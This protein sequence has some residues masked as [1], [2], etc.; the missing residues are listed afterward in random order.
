MEEIKE[1]NVENKEPF[2]AKAK[3]WF[4]KKIVALKRKPQLIYFVFSV[5]VTFLYLCWLFT[6]SRTIY[7]NQAVSWAGLMVFI[8]T[9]VSILLLAL[10]FNAFPKRSK[11]KIVFIVLM[12]VF[13]A[14]IVACDL[15][16][17]IEMN[18]Y[19]VNRSGLTDADFADKPYMKQS[20]TLA[21]T[22]VVLVGIEAI[23][24]ATLPLYKKLI[25]K[26]NTKK[27]IEENKLSEEIDTSEDV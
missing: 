12:F 22:H 17:Y 7:A 23:L 14:V 24:L 5:I 19:F 4:R 16:Y 15:A 11:P 3:E 6:F 10:Y 2:S 1:V 27:V 8:N 26:I 18:D 9:L 20:L 25:L 13:M 21:I